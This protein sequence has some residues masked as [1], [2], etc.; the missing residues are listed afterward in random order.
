MPS[1]QSSCSICWAPVNAGIVLRHI[2]AGDNSAALT[3]QDVSCIGADCA[4]VH[5]GAFQGPGMVATNLTLSLDPAAEAALPGYIWPAQTDMPTIIQKGG[6]A[7]WAIA[8]VAVSVVLAALLA[9]MGGFWVWRHRH[10]AARGQG[11]LD[12]FSKLETGSAGSCSCHGRSE[13]SEHAAPKNGR[14]SRQSSRVCAVH[15]ASCDVCLALGTGSQSPVDSVS[16]INPPAKQQDSVAAHSLPSKALD[17]A[18]MVI[19]LANMDHAVKK[20][21]QQQ[22]QQQ[23]ELD[24]TDHEQLQQG[25]DVSGLRDAP[26]PVHVAESF[27]DSVAAGMQRWRAAVSSTTMLLME[28]RMDAALPVGSTGSGS[29]GSVG[30]PA[31]SSVTLPQE[32]PAEVKAHK[33]QNGRQP[34]VAGQVAE[35]IVGS[36]P[37]QL[38]L[39]ELLG[40]GSFGCV[41]LATWRGKRVAVKIMQLPANALLGPV[42]DK[43]RASEQQQE[44]GSQQDAVQER[45]RQRLARQKQQNSPPHMAIMEAVLSSTMSHPNVVQVYTYV[46]NPLTTSSVPLEGKDGSMA[47]SSTGVKGADNIA[48]WELKIIMEFC[49]EVGIGCCLWCQCTMVCIHQLWRLAIIHTQQSCMALSPSYPS[50]HNLSLRNMSASGLKEWT[51]IADKTS[52][53]GQVRC[54]EALAI[55]VPLTTVHYLSLCAVQ[56]SLRDALDCGSLCKPGSYLA[57]SAVLSLAHDVAAALL[58]LHSEGIVHGDLKAGNVMLTDIGNN[59]CDGAR[60]WSTAGGRRLTAKVADFG[61]AMPLGPS[62]THATLMARVRG[63]WGVGVW[64]CLLAS[65]EQS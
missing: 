13:S 24:V 16:D 64:M 18:H 6:M 29:S 63:S 22:Q 37:P 55:H 11:L 61:L 5:V 30:K 28:R 9:A 35:S 31:G 38:Q 4:G 52:G 36:T 20:F 14:G 57:P 45:Q 47:A 56:G 27:A 3:F 10:Y 48:G 58:H 54:K 51:L 26:V 19:P 21:E 8:V 23:D 42:N 34:A 32:Q 44:K 59:S 17:Q 2:L 41:Y 43:Q 65:I 46:L 49:N 7:P 60:V 33:Q 39:L 50:I 12:P 1:E 62:D 15:G 53:Q 40:Q 25:L